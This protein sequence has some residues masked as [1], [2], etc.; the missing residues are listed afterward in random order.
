MI[1]GTLASRL[2]ARPPGGL[3]SEGKEVRPRR[4]RLL[5]LA[6][7][8][9]VVSFLAVVATWVGSRVPDSAATRRLG[10]GP[11]SVPGLLDEPAR[12]VRRGALTGS[13]NSRPM[14]P[15][16][17]PSREPCPVVTDQERV[18]LSGR[19]RVEGDQSHHTEGDGRE[20]PAA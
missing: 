1:E 12:M 7:A 10:T 11:R 20:A 2:G 8:L 13:L 6:V 18:H 5:W 9:G 3:R 15:G 14:V 16:A 4:R 19:R 17:S